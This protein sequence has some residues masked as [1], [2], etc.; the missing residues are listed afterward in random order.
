MMNILKNNVTDH[1]FGIRCGWKHTENA[2]TKSTD[3]ST[4]VAYSHQMENASKM[5]DLELAL[6]NQHSYQWRKS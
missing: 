1:S 5:C 6:Q 3:S 4:W 2:Q